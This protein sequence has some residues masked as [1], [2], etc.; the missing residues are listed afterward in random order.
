M[1]GIQLLELKAT[2]GHN[3]CPQANSTSSFF[4]ELLEHRE[5]CIVQQSIKQPLQLRLTTFFVEGN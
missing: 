1:V 2:D 3:S 4:N 5:E